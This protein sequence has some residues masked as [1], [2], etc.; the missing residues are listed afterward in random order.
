[1]VK[2]YIERE[3]HSVQAASNGWEAPL[4]FPSPPHNSNTLGWPMERKPLILIVDD[5]I[6]TGAA[7]AKLVKGGVLIREKQPGSADD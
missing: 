5:H 7:L 6:D 4:P 3:G 1:M 2:T